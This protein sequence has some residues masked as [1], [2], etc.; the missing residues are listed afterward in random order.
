MANQGKRFEWLRYVRLHSEA[1][2]RWQEEYSSPEILRL[3]DIP[4]RALKLLRCSKKEEA[5]SLLASYLVDAEAARPRIRNSIYWVLRRWYHSVKAYSV[6]LDDDYEGAKAHLLSAHGAVERAIEEEPA[7]LPLADHCADFRFQ[8]V[9][10]SRNRRRWDDLLEQAEALRSLARSELALCTVSGKDIF[11]TDLRDFLT[12][13]P[14]IDAE[15]VAWLESLMSKDRRL[16]F[17]ER[18]L[19]DVFSIK[20]FVIPYE[21]KA[22]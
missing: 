21:P 22:A 6:Y 11:I 4:D 15:E 13:T 10:I 20:G 18:H 5:D 12:S 9:R 7:L 16:R 8:N 2:A 17:I 14:G 1:G 19:A 3:T